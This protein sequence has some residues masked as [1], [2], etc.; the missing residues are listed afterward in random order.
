MVRA[1]HKT[2]RWIEANPPAALAE[3]IAG[4]YFPDLDRGVL[5]NALTRYKAQG[6]WASNPVLSQEGFDRLQ[7]ALLASGFLGRSVPFADC[8]DN[9][10]AAETARGG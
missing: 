3:L 1:V 9:G 10:L 7:R 2:Q 5:T 8:A 6:V 4:D